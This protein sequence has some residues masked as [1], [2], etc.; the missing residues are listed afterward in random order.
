MTVS[1][2]KPLPPGPPRVVI[3][4]LDQDPLTTSSLGILHYTRNLLGELATRE[5]PGFRVIVMLTP[6]NV[7]ALR[8]DSVPPWMECR[9]VPGR[10]ATGIGRLW[11]DH[12]LG[13][14]L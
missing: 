7:Q 10:F 5:D 6:A 13:P 9:V 1:T 14:R 4:G 8:P 12:V 2:Q 3:Y 11:G